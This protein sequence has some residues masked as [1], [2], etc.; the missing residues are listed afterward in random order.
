M[1]WRL[2]VVR[3]AAAALASEE[4]ARH[5]G[6][7][8][9]VSLSPPGVLV[10]SILELPL[11]LLRLPH[12]HLVPETVGRAE[13]VLPRALLSSLPLP[14]SLRR[15][16]P[17]TR[18]RLRHRPLHSLL[19]IDTHLLQVLLEVRHVPPCSLARHRCSVAALS[20]PAVLNDERLLLLHHRQQCLLLLRELDLVLVDVHHLVFECGNALVLLP[21]Q[22]LEELVD[23]RVD[24]VADVLALHDLRDVVVLPVVVRQLVLLSPVDAELLGVPLDVGVV[25]HPGGCLVHFSLRHGDVASAAALADLLG[26]RGRARSVVP[27]DGHG[28][29][30]AVEDV[31]HLLALHLHLDALLQELLARLLL[32][33]DDALLGNRAHLDHLEVVLRLHLGNESFLL[34]VEVLEAED[35]DLVGRDDEGLVGEEGLDV[36]EE[37]ELLLEAVAALLRDIDHEEHSGAEMGQRGDGLH[38]DG[39]PVLQRVVEDTGGVDDLPWSVL[40]VSVSDEERLGGEGVGLNVDVGPGDLV[41]EAALAHVRVSAEDNRP[42]DGVDRW[43]T[44]EMLTYLLQVRQARP[45]LLHHRAHAAERGLLQSLASVEAVSVLEQTDVV[46]RQIGNVVA[47]VVQLAQGELVVVPVVQHVHEIGVERVDLVEDREVIEDTRELVVEVLLRIL[48]LPHVELP[49]SADSIALVNDRWRLPV[50]LR[51]DDVNEVVRAGHDLNLFEVVLRH[52]C[53]L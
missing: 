23:L 9:S 1:A 3:L 44:A 50:G 43:Q 31:A 52:G 7:D 40:V 20:Q 19:R 4:M 26:D 16:R 24:V 37:T 33:G 34:V 45:L 25:G 48:D 14:V 6:L 28:H 10:P 18:A 39:I 29:V 27:G 15:P 17:S 30:Q 42:R 51:Q 21:L 38:L 5:L 46:L 41:D 53:A 22:L 32:D 11:E 49:D 12:L 47:R 2:S 36:V 13:R 8:L 35:V